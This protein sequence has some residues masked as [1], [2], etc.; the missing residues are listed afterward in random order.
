[1]QEYKDETNT[2]ITVAQG[3]WSITEGGEYKVSLYTPAFTIGYKRMINAQLVRNIANNIVDA[4]NSKFGQDCWNTCNEEQRCWLP[5]SR[6]SFYL[7][8]PNFEQYN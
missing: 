7:Q 8:I 2:H 6:V 4:L 1:M 3:S 5:L